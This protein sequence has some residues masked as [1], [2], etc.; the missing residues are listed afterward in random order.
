MTPDSE[1]VV[2]RR[3]RLFFAVTVPDAIK[4]QLL[5][6]QSALMRDA[7]EARIGWTRPEQLHL[8]LRFLGNVDVVQ[9]PALTTAASRVLAQFGPLELHAQE[10][11]FFPVHGLPRV[12]WAG[13]RENAD[14]LPILQQAL[15]TATLP[16]AKEAS[17]E[18]FCGHI[19][20]GRVKA[21]KRREAVE[22]QQSAEK[23]RG[24][25]L[26]RWKAQ[27]VEL[28]R[29]ELS[30]QG[31]RHLVLATFGLTNLASGSTSA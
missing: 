3:Y 25:Q 11:G 18:S 23:F 20:L 6:A 31:T 19:T 22:L 29:S 30:S 8:T 27:T 9:V 12:I 15:Q 2:P 16:F 17:E 4:T 5:G 14:R 24:T 21:I 7:R 28:F 26:G 10:I 13:V 1:P